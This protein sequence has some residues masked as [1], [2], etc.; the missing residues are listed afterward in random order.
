MSVGPVY[1]LDAN[2]RWEIGVLRVLSLGAGVQST[3][4]ALMAANGDHEAP[5]CAIFAD[6]G[7]EPKAVYEHLAR[8]IKALPFPVHIVSAGNLREDAI[9]GGSKRAGERFAAVPWF[10]R[11]PNGSEGM[12]RR[13]CTAHYKLKPIHRKI[14]ELQG[15]KR[16]K[17]G[18]EMWIGIS[19]DEAMR[20]K[21]SRVQY[22][23]NRW[24]L[25]ERDISR[26][27]CHAILAKMGWNAP[28]SSCIGCPFHSD[29]Q[30]RT[31]PPDELADAIEVDRAIRKQPGMKGDQFMHRKRIPLHEVDLRSDAEIGQPDLFMNDCEGMC[32]V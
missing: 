18:C 22:I 10:L 3:T 31:L 26:G 7:W 14:V 13:Q 11:N 24:P 8:L 12:G 20:M 23:R 9:A 30:W 5:D 17:G 1:L 21:P 15:G 25:I 19:T 6:T 27:K 4:L 32:G 28:K 16:S 2:L 29:A